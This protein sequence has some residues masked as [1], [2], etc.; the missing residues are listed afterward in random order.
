MLLTDSRDVVLDCVNSQNAFAV[1][2]ADYD[3]CLLAMDRSPREC[4]C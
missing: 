3:C 2:E 4:S 1:T